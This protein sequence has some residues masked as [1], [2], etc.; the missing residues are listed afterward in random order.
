[1][2]PTV[3]LFDIDGTLVS[4]GGAG[5]RSIERAFVEHTGTATVVDFSFAGMTDP[6]IVRL[7]LS[8]AGRTVDAGS[9][10]AVLA[11]Y[12]RAL[13]EEVSAAERFVVHEG[14]TEV[15]IEV[16]SWDRSAV[17]LGTGNIRDG[18]RVKLGRPGLFERFGFGGFGCDAEDRAELLRV[19]AERGAE[20]LGL[21]RADCRVVVIGDTP[22]DV[23]A[24]L[25]IGAEAIGVGTGPYTA[26]DLLACGAARAFR[27]LTEPGVLEA[28]RGD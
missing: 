11:S 19:G 3:L 21:P 7:G 2:R 20:R 28:L 16:L 5:R 6:A 26:E 15:L 9:I 22:K 12:L 17:G 13:E 24:A 25:A 23:A 8:R 18:A 4:T 1:M 10:A 14:V 27:N